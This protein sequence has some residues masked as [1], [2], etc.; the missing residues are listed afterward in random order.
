MSDVDVVVIGAGHNGLFAACRLARAGMSV[1]VVEAND[2]PGGAVWSL[3]T[4]GDG[5]LHDVGAGFIAFHDSAAFRG[6][7]LEDHGLSFAQGEV[8][9]TNPA[10]DGTVTALSQ[11]PELIDLGSPSDTE[12]FRALRRWHQGLEPAMMGFL[13]PIGRLKPVWDLGPLRG[14]KL[15]SLFARSPAGLARHLFH[16]AAARRLMPSMGLHVDLGP[17]DAMASAVGYVLTMRSTTGGFAVPIGGAKAITEALVSCLEAAGGTLELG[18]RVSQVEVHQGRATGVVLAGGRRIR[19]KKAVVSNTSAPALY[20]D[21]LD[22]SWV[23]RG[24]KRRM[25]SFP[26][27]WGTFK[28]DLSLEGPVPWADEPSRKSAVVHAAE[29]LDDLRRF[30]RQVRGGDLPDQPYLVIG[31]QSLVD[32]TRAPDGRHTLYAYTHVPARLDPVRYPGGWAAWRERFADRIE[33]R[34]EGLAPGFRALVRGRAVHDPGD[35]EAMSSNL[36]GSDLGAGTAHVH[37]QLVLRP[38]FPWFRHRTPVRGLYLS[39]AFTHPGT[40]AHGLCGWNAAEMVL[41]DA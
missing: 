32:S 1:H 39:S 19:A 3:D 23:P 13:G 11:D 34:I 38:A 40:G 22:G 12:A 33:A 36:L 7:P 26:L 29:G 16:G 15:A 20:L 4:T 2:R 6:L 17:D 28:V 8:Q 24:V 14:L 5:S 41:A 18:A 31:Q 10:L 27:G 25:R 30:T 35:L 21:L 9:S 37:N